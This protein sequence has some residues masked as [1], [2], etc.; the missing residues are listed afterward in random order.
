[1]VHSGLDPHKRALAISTVDAEGRPGR[2]A[3]PPTRREAI[4]AYFAD[5]A[6]GSGAQQAVVESTSNRYWLRDLLTGRGVDLRL[7][8]SKHVKRR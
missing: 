5:L 2:D 1:M 4:T 8:H 6:G 3:Q 7:A